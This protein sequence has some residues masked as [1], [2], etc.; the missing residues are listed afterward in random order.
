MHTRWLL[1]RYTIWVL[2]GCGN[3]AAEIYSYL[4]TINLTLT[5]NSKTNKLFTINLSLT[6]L[7]NTNSLSMSTTN[8]PIF[9]GIAISLIF[10]ASGAVAIVS[11]RNKNLLVTRC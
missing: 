4:L 5:T 8:L 6:N 10:V 11:S 7:H 9:T 1:I 3:L 2:G